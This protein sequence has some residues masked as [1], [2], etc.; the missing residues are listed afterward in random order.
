MSH[1]PTFYSGGRHG[2]WAICACGW[3][4]RTWTTTVGAH[5]EFGK[6]LIEGDEQ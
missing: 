4:S 3:K 1:H 6:H 2:C 5:L